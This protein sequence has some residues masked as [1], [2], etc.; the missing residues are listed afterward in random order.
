MVT[1]MIY[2]CS[3][4]QDTNQVKAISLVENDQDTAAAW[5]S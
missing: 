1:D 4:L 2:G 5:Q 3:L